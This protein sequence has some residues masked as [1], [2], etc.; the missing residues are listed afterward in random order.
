MQL[1][2]QGL[3]PPS[4]LEAR[5]VASR[6]VCRP[7]ARIGRVGQRWEPI[8]MGTHARFISNDR[9][10]TRVCSTSSSSQ[11]AQPEQ[12]HTPSGNA[13]FAPA[14]K[15]LGS[16]AL[17]AVAATTGFAGPAMAQSR[18]RFCRSSILA[19]ACGRTGDLALAGRRWEHQHHRKHQPWL[20]TGLL[21]GGM[22]AIQA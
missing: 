13:W 18:Y 16:V 12:P 7:V 17:L 11:D 20:M 6:L 21:P 1:L 4:R 5:C 19:S 8:S 9:T 3:R 22:Q 15:V 2:R 14:A 10:A